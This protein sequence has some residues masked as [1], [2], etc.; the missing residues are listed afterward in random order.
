MK[1]IKLYLCILAL[2]TALCGATLAY[3]YKLG[4]ERAV[5]KVR[6]AAAEQQVAALQAQKQKVDSIFVRDT[7]RLRLAVTRWDTVKAGYDTV[8]VSVPAE[9]VQ[10]IV[11]AAQQT[12]TACGVALVSCGERVRIRDSIIDSYKQQIALQR[13]ALK[14]HTLRDAFIG[15]VTGFAAGTIACYF[16][17]KE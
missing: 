11:E 14:T 8:T 5:L 4:G 12:I 3:T 9:T 10:V 13:P 7:V 2:L 16:G 17:C 6:I 15:A 1:T